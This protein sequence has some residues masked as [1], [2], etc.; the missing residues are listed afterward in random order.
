MVRCCKPKASDRKELS[1]SNGRSTKWIGKSPTELY[2][3][4]IEDIKA[5]LLLTKRRIKS[6]LKG[7]RRYLTNQKLSPLSVKCYKTG[8]MSFY[9]SFEIKIPKTPRSEKEHSLCRRIAIYLQRKTYRKSLR[10]TIC[11]KSNSIN[12]SCKRVKCSGNN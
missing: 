5:G 8:V 1:P 9:R 7:F 3:E 4:A 10:Y 6:N 11:G 2:N 12:R